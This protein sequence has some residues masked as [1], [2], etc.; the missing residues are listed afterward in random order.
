MSIRSGSRL[1]AMKKIP[2]DQAMVLAK[3]SANDP[4]GAG[5]S[6]TRTWWNW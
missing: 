3:L 2:S 4:C 6:S 5:N 1:S